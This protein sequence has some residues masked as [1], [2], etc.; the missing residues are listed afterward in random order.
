MNRK[1][2]LCFLLGALLLGPGIGVSR[3]G[4]ITWEFSG[5]I[6]R[7]SDANDLLGGTVIDGTPFSGSFTFESTVTDSDPGSLIG[8]YEDVVLEIHGQVGGL[9]FSGPL[10]G[11]FIR[12]RNSST[13]LYRV[14]ADVEFLGQQLDFGLVAPRPSGLLADTSLPLVPPDFEGFGGPLTFSIADRTEVLE[15]GISGHV[16]VIVPEP[17]TALFLAG[18]LV[19]AMVKR[20]GCCGETS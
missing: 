16:N 2:M 4:P 8:L 20:G 12:I 14:D 3:A 19:L 11:N 10:G 6:F 17:A 5:E 13:D 1:R 7:V 18:T 9:E 15:F